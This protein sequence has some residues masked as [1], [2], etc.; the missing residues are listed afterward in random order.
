MTNSAPHP[1][2]N[3]VPD[4]WFADAILAANTRTYLGTPRVM[5][6]EDEVRRPPNQVSLATLVAIAASPPQSASAPSG[7]A[8]AAAYAA[9][10]AHSGSRTA[11]EELETL[12]APRPNVQTLPDGMEY[13]SVAARGDELPADIARDVLEPVEPAGAAGTFSRASFDEVRRLFRERATAEPR[14]ELDYRSIELRAADQA[15]FL[16]TYLGDWSDSAISDYEMLARAFREA[17][18]SELPEQLA[19]RLSFGPVSAGH[20]IDITTAVVTVIQRELGAHHRG[21]R[22]VA[23]HTIDR[24]VRRE[25]GADHVNI[26][27]MESLR[28]VAAE[29]ANDIC[30]ATY[31]PRRSL[32]PDEAALRDRTIQQLGVPTH[33]LNSTQQP[34]A[35]EPLQAERSVAQY[36]LAHY[37]A[38]VAGDVWGEADD[39]RS[40]IFV[41]QVTHVFDIP[42]SVRADGFGSAGSRSWLQWVDLAL[43][44]DWVRIWPYPQVAFRRAD[45]A[46]LAAAL[47]PSPRNLVLRKPGQRDAPGESAAGPV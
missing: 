33:V 20:V 24:A 28:A 3:E 44:G 14:A 25:C 38:P 9:A 17:L 7:A 47:A 40:W 26:S 2:Q 35:P 27:H 43:N 13:H 31:P 37:V 10:Y 30:R 32:A 18:V 11:V 36:A 16:D 39:P 22:G 42:A 23:Q 19:R 6:R 29:I 15:A 21:L 1:P 34:E 5:P 46:K 45:D 41:R 4:S 12:E 8:D